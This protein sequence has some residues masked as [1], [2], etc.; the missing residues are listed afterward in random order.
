MSPLP[1]LYKYQGIHR[2][3]QDHRYCHLNHEAHQLNL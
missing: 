2:D 1:E 3:P